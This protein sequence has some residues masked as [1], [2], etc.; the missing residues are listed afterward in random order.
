MSNLNNRF[1]IPHTL[2]RSWPESATSHNLFGEE[3]H[4]IKLEVQL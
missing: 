4:Y 3:E 2:A 1:Q